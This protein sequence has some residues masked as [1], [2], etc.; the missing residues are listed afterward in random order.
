MT[1]PLWLKRSASE[2]VYGRGFRSG[3]MDR[4]GRWLSRTDAVGRTSTFERDKAG[5]LTRYIAPNGNCV[6][7]TL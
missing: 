6:D 7:F 2:R 5:N 3:T 1:R 4:Y